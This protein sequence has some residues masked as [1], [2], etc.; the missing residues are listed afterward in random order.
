[1]VKFNAKN[2]TIAVLFGVLLIGVIGIVNAQETLPKGGDGF[3][4]AVEIKPG[5]YKGRSLES[6]EVEYFYIAGIKPG[7]EIKINGTFTP[8]TKFSAIATLDL[9]DENRTDLGVG[10]YESGE[11]TMDISCEVSWMTNSDRETYKYYIRTGSDTWNITSYLLDISLIDR[12]DAGSQKDAGD[13]VEKAMS[14]KSGEY[15]SYLS[16]EKGADAKDF[17]KVAVKKGQ[18]LAAK[19]TPPSE[20]SI[21]I[22][23][24]DSNRKV[25]KDEYA[26]NPGAIITNSV[27]ITKSGD[28]FVGVICDKY[29]SKELVA[30]TLNIATEGVL[31]E[32]EEYD[33]EGLPYYGVDGAVP[34]DGVE[35]EGS[36]WTLILG[37]IALII[38]L[39]I[40]VYFLLKK[41]K[42]RGTTDDPLNL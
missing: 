10:C 25:L 16:G 33:E 29:C 22:T 21:R 35:K 32:E 38:I 19:V 42:K 27:P 5:S 36:N 12:Y 13:T 34:G 39:G 30:Y 18:T 6:H 41:K 24:Y 40:V 9:Y 28:V 2:L 7:Q 14:V 37:I 26:P 20:A 4:T 31:V 17:Y 8:E 3:D 11:G 1:M 23:V 15:K